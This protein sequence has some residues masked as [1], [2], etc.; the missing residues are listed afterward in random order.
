MSKT[1]TFY[2][3]TTPLLLQF[4]GCFGFVSSDNDDLIMA[5][6]VPSRQRVD[7]A[8][9]SKLETKVHKL[10]RYMR[11]ENLDVSKLFECD[12]DGEVPNAFIK[13]RIYDKPFP[14]ASE[15]VIV[16]YVL[17]NRKGMK[18]NANLFMKKLSLQWCDVDADGAGKLIPFYG[19]IVFASSSETASL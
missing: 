6:R 11:K 3:C 10:L 7:V 2:Y 13:S 5:E 19:L 4:I 8:T 12:D 17:S 18:K 15:Y 14:A 1:P 16:E 9:I